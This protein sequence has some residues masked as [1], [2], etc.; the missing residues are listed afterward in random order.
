[1]PNPYLPTWE[2]IPDGEPRVFGDRLYVY[3]SHDRFGGDYFCMN[4]YVCWSAPLDD[5]ESWRY[6][7]VIWRRAWDPMPVT[8]ATEYMFAP[9]A[10]QGSDG[11]YY[12]YYGTDMYSRIAVA[13][14]DTPAGEYRFHGE[15]H[16]P[17]G[18]RYGGRNGEVI[19]FDP[20]VLHDTDG[21]TWLYTGFSSHS[22]WLAEFSAKRGYSINGEGAQVVRLD[23][24]MLTVLTEPKTVVPGL[25]GEKD[26]DF[27]GHSFFEASSIRHF[28][29]KYYFIYSSCLSHELAYAVS[30]RPDGG[31][32]YAGALHSNCNI[33]C[34][35]QTS[36][37]YYYGNNHGSI[38]EIGG[39]YYIFGH[40][41]TGKGGYARQGVAEPLTMDENGLFSQ[42]EMTSGGLSGVLKADRTY[43]AAIACVL[44]DGDEATGVCDGNSEERAARA[45]ITQDG[46][47]RECAPGQYIKNIHEGTTVG[48]KY[49]DLAESTVVTLS[50]RGSAS[51]I[52]SVK[53]EKCGAPVAKI[54]LSPS[55]SIM[56][57]SECLPKQS[58][59]TAIYLTFEGSGS[60][61]LYEIGFIPA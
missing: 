44:Y 18:V 22:K 9:D 42:A 35:G 28:D 55:E 57:Y 17:D 43:E 61:D 31:F 53:S 16:Y 38:A 59:K 24:D 48:Y 41:Q 3:G 54:A 10:V 56:T 49:F 21:S 37:E 33:G 27:E 39:R 46:E 29:D 45:Q 20:A 25:D 2:Y 40:R 5:L 1:M 30:D 52:I 34:N 36:P 4:D 11:R 8:E 32:A 47:D 12:L 6:E 23:D 50:I 26:T 13:V 7:G 58:E 60:F 15:V 19:R 14:S 51:G